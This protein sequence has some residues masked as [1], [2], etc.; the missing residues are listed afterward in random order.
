MKRFGS[1]PDSKNWTLRKAYTPQLNLRLG[2]DRRHVRR[3]ASFNNDFSTSFAIG[4]S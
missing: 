1:V 3:I 4:D 2:M